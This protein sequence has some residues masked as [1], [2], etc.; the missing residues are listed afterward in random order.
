MLDLL[1]RGYDAR[2]AASTALLSLA[3]TA[4]ASEAQPQLPEPPRI[5]TLAELQ[6]ALTEAGVLV[7]EAPDIPA[8]ELGVEAH[9]L[10]V[11]SAPVQAYEYGSVVERRLVSDT[12]RAGGYLVSGEPVDW[13]ARPNIWTTG[14]LIVVYPG[15]DG[16]TVLL[17]SGLLGDPLTF[18]APAIDEPYPP[19]VLA[20]IGA[21]AVQSGVGPEQVEVLSYEPR[22]WPDGCL[23]LPGPDEMCTEAIV[24]GWIVRLNVSGDPIVY[25]ADEVG[26]ELRQE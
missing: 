10:L 25:R 18:E 5:E 14:Q 6:T 2:R 11:G 20:A 23:G 13:P 4:C 12:I 7:S 3:L 26:V 19:V 8:P 17:L 22:E 15:M 9:G 21:A 1:L 16:G 24:P